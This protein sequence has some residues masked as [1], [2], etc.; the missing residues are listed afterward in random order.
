LLNSY[1]PLAAL[2]AAGWVGFT[3]ALVDR[4]SLE[5]VLPIFIEAHNRLETIN[6]FEVLMATQA[7]PRA[8]LAD[9]LKKKNEL[10]VSYSVV[11]QPKL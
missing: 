3:T 5:A 6:L 9:L 11:N 2:T 7:D 4:N 10:S 8:E 1:A